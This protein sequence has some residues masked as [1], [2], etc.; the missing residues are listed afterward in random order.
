MRNRN[1][2]CRMLAALAAAVML[3]GAVGNIPTA[4][5][6]ADTVEGKQ[7]SRLI[8]V[9]YDDS[10]SM[11]LD[12]RLWWC[13]AKYSLEVFSAMMQDRDSMNIYYMSDDDSAPRI[14]NLS[15]DRN[16][17][18]S[19]ISKIHNTVTNTSGT[20]FASIRRAYN[21]LKGS[22]GYDEKWLM[23]ITDGDSFNQNE[24]AADID[25]LISDCA[26]H[27][28]KVVY[29]AIGDALVPTDAPSR[30]VYVYK[31]DGQV[32]FGSTGI[33]ARVTQI[34]QRI[35]Q[36]PS[37][38]ASTSSKI[39]IDIPVSEIIV[40][41]Q[42][43]NVS[44]GE[45]SGTRKI[46]STVAMNG[47]DKDKATINPYYKDGI[48]VDTL[49]ASIATFVPKNGEY[50]AEGTYDLPVTA[51][52]Y[53]VYYKP[54]LDVVLRLLDGKGNVMTEDY[55]P[56]GSYT[57]QYWLTYPQ[58]HPK[59]GE[60]ISQSLFDVEYTR[61]CEVDGSTRV[62]SSDKVDLSAG[63]TT[64]RVVADYLNFSS[65]DASL[66][67]V[68]EDFTVNELDVTVEYLQK[69][70]RLSTLETDNEGLLVKVSRNGSPISGAEWE[71][72]E[73]KFDIDN[74]D[75]R[76]IKN[77]DSSFNVYPA[78]KN[79]DKKLTATGDIDFKITA[80]ASN[81]HRVTDSGTARASINIYDDV[82][83]VD[84]GVAVEDQDGPCD[85]KN[86]LD[87][88]T[89]RRVVIDWAGKNLTREQYDALKLSVDINDKDFIA[90]V[91][92]DPYEEGKPTTATVRFDLVRDEEGNIPAPKKL[93]GNKR[94]TVS[95]EI[96]S[97]GQISTGSGTGILAVD[98]AR[99]LA[100]LLLEW[101]IPLII[102]GI[103]LL[104][105][106][107]YAPII[108]RYLPVSSRYVVGASRR[109]ISWYANPLAII[110]LLCPFV[111][112][113]S[114]ATVTNN[115]TVTVNLQVKAERGRRVVCTNAENVNRQGY[116]LQNAV[117]TGK[118]QSINL[119]SLT[120]S[121]MRGPAVVRFSR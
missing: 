104:L 7:V 89:D 82:S 94:F 49:N 52:E 60:K 37:L 46:L 58:S 59:Y 119:G 56:I 85:N 4:A 11:L 117:A 23:V 100:E 73:L 69:D 87:Q 115:T 51:D 63:R 98:D 101:K 9:V 66:V 3:F 42:G 74:P 67:Y 68:V 65:S 20:P 81:D 12:N 70:Y 41:A 106:L 32:S 24:S 77:G 90:T 30:G 16:R 43:S 47:S 54:C 26:S 36:R 102:L 10:N 78:Y 19:N 57:L 112:V 83:A 39:K 96:D 14:S 2:F 95:A 116:K 55:I 71:R 108:K 121:R 25:A 75:F 61:T 93:N 120:I 64:I 113:R 86:F 107:A 8:N 88:D 17:Q 18:Q 80:S 62:L 103:I 5:V 92:L 33:L 53:V 34:C 72:F 13:Y 99:T 29:L 38:N 45:I 111:R 105:L 50:I 109:S 84:L 114:Y 76:V 48:N 15:G 44:I 31:A 22:G 6:Y 21:D 110:T 35:F 1:V 91:E 118:S 28:V 40:F 79:G 97:D 27:N